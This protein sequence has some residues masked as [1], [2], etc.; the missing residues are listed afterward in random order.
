MHD[1]PSKQTFAADYRF[2]SH[3]CVRVDGIYDLATWL[4]NANSKEHWDR[5]AI[6]DAVRDGGQKRIDI[7]E[8][9]PAAWIYLDAWASADGTVHYRPEVYGLDGAADRH[10]TRR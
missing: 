10:Q 1:T 7:A 2:V 8:P 4:L 6:V 5:D 9:V 3:G